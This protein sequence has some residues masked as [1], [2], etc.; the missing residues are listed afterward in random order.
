LPVLSPSWFVLV[1]CIIVLPLLAV[2]LFMRWIGRQTH[3]SFDE[4]TRAWG[5]LTALLG[6]L[7]VIVGGAMVV[8]K[9][10]DEQGRLRQAELQA[11]ERE[12]TQRARA[13][14]SQQATRLQAEHDR[15]QR[16]YDATMTAATRLRALPAGDIAAL[17]SST[18]RGEYED[19]YWARLIG[20]ESPDV[21]GA[22]VR[23]RE[24]LVKWE[25]S[26]VKP[27]EELGPAVLRLSTVCHEHLTSLQR[28][29]AVLE[30][31]AVVAV[32]RP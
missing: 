22:M 11:Q 15:L 5:V 9:Y 7:T 1:V 10:A 23:Y 16:L 24:L 17:T 6:S 26:G 2:A 12:S 29:I 27:T 8:G 19:L 14:T 18:V 13:V 28:Q 25:S 30:E 20:L 4:K 32:P 31:R 3:L 21:E